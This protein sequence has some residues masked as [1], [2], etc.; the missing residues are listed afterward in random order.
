[1][2][3]ESRGGSAAFTFSQGV[4]GDVPEVTDIAKPV[5][6]MVV[7]VSVKNGIGRLSTDGGGCS[8]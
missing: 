4:A 3:V 8:R 5:N 7:L 1:M 6:A 2:R